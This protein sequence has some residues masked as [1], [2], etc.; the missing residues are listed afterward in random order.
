MI[1]R[2][3][4]MLFNF[5][6]NA[7]NTL[8]FTWTVDYSGIKRCNNLFEVYSLGMGNIHRVKKASYEMQGRALRVYFYNNLWHYFG[9]IPLLS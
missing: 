3:W 5:E 6:A 9:N 4:H 7:S 8:E 2:Q 1:T